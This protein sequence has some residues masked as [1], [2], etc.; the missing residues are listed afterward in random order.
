M[1]PGRNFAKQKIMGSLA[2]FLAWL[3]VEMVGWVTRDGVLP[4]DREG[5]DEESFALSRPDRD[6]KV[7]VTRRR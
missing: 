4:S 6:F 1:C 5:R 2:S 7:R 3:D